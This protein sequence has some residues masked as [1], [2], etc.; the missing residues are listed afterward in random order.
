MDGK[1]D[2]QTQ[3]NCFEGGGENSTKHFELV[4]GMNNSA[5]YF[6]IT[7]I[8]IIVEISFD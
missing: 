4:I 6:S 3:R 5:T 2:D 7:N 1:W 8:F